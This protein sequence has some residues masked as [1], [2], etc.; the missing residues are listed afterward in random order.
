MK[1]PDAALCCTPNTG[2]Q[3]RDGDTWSWMGKEGFNSWKKFFGTERFCQGI[4]GTE[5]SC[6][7]PRTNTLAQIVAKREGLQRRDMRL[8]IDD[9]LKPIDLAQMEIQDGQPLISV[10]SLLN[11][12]ALR[13]Q[14]LAYPSPKRLIRFGNQD[15]RQGSLLPP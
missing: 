9:D 4:A 14:N 2:A 8:Q 15:A 6:S 3:L 11:M 10:A 7:M 5:N 13:L 1:Q 12:I